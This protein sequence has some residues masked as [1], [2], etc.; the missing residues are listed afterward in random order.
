[1]SP[2]AFSFA[3]LDKRIEQMPNWSGELKLYPKGLTVWEVVGV[4][5]TLMGLLPSLLVQFTAPAMW[6]VY[7]AKA[8]VIMA[9]L[10]FLPSFLYQ[11]LSLARAFWQWRKDFVAA[12]DHAFEQH[13]EL[14]QWLMRFPKEELE[15]R[16]QFLRGVQD[17]IGNR[18]ALVAGSLVKLGFVPAFIAVITQIQEY[19][20]LGSLPGWRIYLAIFLIL[21]YGITLACSLTVMRA[22]FYDGLLGRAINSINK[23]SNETR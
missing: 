17:R 10:G 14:L 22:Q 13:R 16:M 23:K 21:I 1:M 11:C 6:M 15:D 18:L 3:E 2:E 5:G 20:D 19:R 12:A 9:G 4:L 7:V 8:G